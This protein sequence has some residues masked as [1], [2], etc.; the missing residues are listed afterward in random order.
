M[1]NRVFVVL[2]DD[3]AHTLPLDLTTQDSDG[4][5]DCTMEDNMS[6]IK[7]KTVCAE[8]GPIIHYDKKGN[9]KE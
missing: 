4:Y 2:A 6:S 3:G 5:D 8:Y 9:V 1:D 7:I